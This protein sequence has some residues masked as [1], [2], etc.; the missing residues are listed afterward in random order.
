MSTPSIDIGCL[1]VEER[2]ELIETLWESLVADPSCI[3]VTDAQKRMLDERLN[4]I[5]SGDDVGIPWRNVKA[6]VQTKLS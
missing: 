1:N 2:L 3:P 5:D 4:E 6:R